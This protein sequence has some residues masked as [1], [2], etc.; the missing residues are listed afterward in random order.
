MDTRR[1]PQ[2]HRD[3]C[4]SVISTKK[5]QNNGITLDKGKDTKAKEMKTVV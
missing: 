5:F 3:T 1:N 2:T 4:M